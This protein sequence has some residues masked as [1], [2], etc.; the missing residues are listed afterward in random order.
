MY[1]AL[2]SFFLVVLSPSRLSSSLGHARVIQSQAPQARAQTSPAITDPRITSRV[3]GLY[4]PV[5]CEAGAC[6][7]PC[8]LP[9]AAIFCGAPFEKD[10]E[11]G[12]SLGWQPTVDVHSVNFPAPSTLFQAFT[13]S[14]SSSP[15][16]TFGAGASK[17]FAFTPSAATKTLRPVASHQLEAPISVANVM[18][19]A[20]M[21]PAHIN[22]TPPA[23][24]LPGPP[25]ALCL[26]TLSVFS[27]VVADAMAAV[28]QQHAAAFPPPA[29]APPGVPVIPGFFQ[30]RPMGNTPKGHPLAATT[31]KVTAPKK[32]AKARKAPVPAASESMLVLVILIQVQG[33]GRPH[34]TAVTAPAGESMQAPAIPNH[35]PVITTQAPV[36]VTLTGA[37]ATAEAARIRCEDA[38]NCNIWA[39]ML[40]CEKVV[41]AKAAVEVAEAK[42]KR[43]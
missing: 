4:P 17:L 33:Q 24:C 26:S 43:A 22:T 21:T 37:T 29:V 11:V 40:Q 31:K 15:L 18:P 20:T 2:S 39:E 27:A 35:A 41:D 14:S 12:G 42:R 38:V 36:L 6:A 13:N 8:T 9:H 28:K 30:S 3:L 34:K 5:R 16:L 32:P 10:Y 25:F 1:T 23:P 7:T 19:Q